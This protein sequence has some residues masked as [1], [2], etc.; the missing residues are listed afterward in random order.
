MKS[1]RNRDSTKVKESHKERV[2]TSM[3]RMKGETSRSFLT[4]KRIKQ[5]VVLSPFV[6]I[7]VI[8]SIIK[9]FKTTKKYKMGYWNL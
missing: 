5:E 3:V 9:Q 2:R 7:I 1:L 6:F 8:D 4:E